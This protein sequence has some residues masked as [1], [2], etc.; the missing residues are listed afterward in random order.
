MPKRGISFGGALGSAKRFLLRYGA[1]AGI[2]AAGAAVA[3]GT[4][5]RPLLAPETR[6]LAQL[7]TAPA[8]AVGLPIAYAFKRGWVRV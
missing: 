2:I 1:K 7:V 8:F 6:P 4:M 3:A 5:Y